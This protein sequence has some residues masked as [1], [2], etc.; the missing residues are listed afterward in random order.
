LEFAQK[1]WKRLNAL[2][3]LLPGTVHKRSNEVQRYVPDLGTGER[4][5]C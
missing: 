1:E 3:M 2:G 4:A 5:Q